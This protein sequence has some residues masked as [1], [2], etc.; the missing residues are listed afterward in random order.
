MSV[1]SNIELDIS[2]IIQSKEEFRIKSGSYIINKTDIVLKL[3]K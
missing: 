1:V 3:N 2:Y